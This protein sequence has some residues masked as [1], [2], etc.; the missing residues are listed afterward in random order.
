MRGAAFAVVEELPPPRE[1]LVREM[2]SLEDHGEATAGLQSNFG[3]L[4]HSKQSQI[5]PPGEKLVGFLRACTNAAPIPK[6]KTNRQSRGAQ[7]RIFAPFS[8]RAPTHAPRPPGSPRGAAPRP[9]DCARRRHGA[10]ALGEKTACWSKKR[11]AQTAPRPFD[12]A[13]GSPLYNPRAMRVYKERRNSR[14][15]PAGPT[16]PRPSH[17]QPLYH[18]PPQNSNHARV[19]L[20]PHRP[21]RSPG[22]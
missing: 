16:H 9:S 20:P 15:R 21:G 22:R 3:G 11:P 5:S 10:P 7:H 4:I 13:W 14:P 8:R 17:L 2:G 18:Q 12:G 6:A 19:R 1:T